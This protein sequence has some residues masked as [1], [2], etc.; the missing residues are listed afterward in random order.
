MNSMQGKRQ[1]QYSFIVSSISVIL[2]LI[3]ICVLGWN[4]V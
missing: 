4:N 1:N 2:L 3:G